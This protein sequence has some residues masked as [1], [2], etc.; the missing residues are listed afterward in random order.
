MG[1][2]PYRTIGERD[3]FAEP[4]PPAAEAP[5]VDAKN[6]DELAALALDNE[7]F[8]TEPAESPLTPTTAAALWA[9]VGVTVAFLGF[10][11]AWA[12]QAFSF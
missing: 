4:L 12:L 6:D 7:N 10:V 11:Y 8:T 5:P 9:A 3:A 1:A 2:S